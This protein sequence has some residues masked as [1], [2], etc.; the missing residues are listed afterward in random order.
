[1]TADMARGRPHE[2]GPAE[3]PTTESSTRIPDGH[4][5]E[6]RATGLAVLAEAIG[7]RTSWPSPADPL[8]VAR[9]FLG[10]TEMHRDGIVTLRWWRGAFYGWTGTHWAE[11][12][13]DAIRAK[14]YG[15]QSIKVVQRPLGH[16]DAHETLNVYAH[17]WPDS[18]DSTREA[19]DLVLGAE[20]E[21]TMVAA[22]TGA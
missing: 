20:A 19:V 5:E 10:I 7:K 15:G 8:E 22:D 9:Y 12:P 16:K 3:T 17:L 6:L 11:V 21:R 1:M 2:S 4:D 14:L 18:D 13:R